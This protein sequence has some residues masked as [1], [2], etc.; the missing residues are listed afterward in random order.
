MTDFQI[1]DR[2]KLAGTELEGMVIGK[3][4]GDI[5]YEVRCDNG[6]YMRELPPEALFLIQEPTST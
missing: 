1:G 6:L 2:V 4:Y 5:R 3:S